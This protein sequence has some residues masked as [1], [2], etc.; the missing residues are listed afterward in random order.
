[1]KLKELKAG[2]IVWYLPRFQSRPIQIEIKKLIHDEDAVQAVD[3]V[4]HKFMVAKVDKLADTKKEA[5]ALG[6]KD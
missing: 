5:K 1:M 4:N 3:L 6:K 2:D